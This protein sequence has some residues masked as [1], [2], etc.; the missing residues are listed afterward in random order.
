MI[1]L[2]AV[3]DRMQIEALRGEATDAVMT[4]D[5]VASLFTPDAVVR[6]PHI[7]TEAVS[8]EE[9]RAGSEVREEEV[10]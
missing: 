2:Q 9:I 8:R 10:T 7:G 3:A 4:R 5:R 1:D 6:I